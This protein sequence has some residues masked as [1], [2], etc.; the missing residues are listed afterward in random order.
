MK[1]R[2]LR[3]TLVTCIV[4]T[5]LFSGGIAYAQDE[6]LPTPGITP[7]SPFYFFDNLGKDIGMFFTFGPEAKA[8]KALQYAEER[9]SEAQAMAGKNRVKEMEKAADGYDKFMAM[10]TERLGEIASHETSDNISERV[11]LATAKHL[12]IL[13][14]VK[15]KVPEKARDAILKARDASINGQVT[16]LQALGINKPERALDISSDTIEKLMERARFRISENVTADNVTGDVE[17]ELDYA[18]RIEKLEDELAAIAE[19]K[20]IDINA[21]QQ[22]LAQSTTNR[23]DVLSGVYE[24][25]PES[26]RPAIENAIENSVRKYERAVEK[27]KEKNTPQEITANVTALQKLPEPIKEKLKIRVTNKA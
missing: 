19:E 12:A 23:L 16:A 8:R 9:L 22:H 3:I 13:D 27:L 6:E 24:K 17:E 10:V 1:R 20:G 7:D 2:L 14:G 18:D 15:D 25:A 11:A 4:I 26:A 21:I 5:S